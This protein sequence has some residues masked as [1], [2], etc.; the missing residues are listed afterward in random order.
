MLIRQGIWLIFI[1]LLVTCSSC[2]VEISAGSARNKQLFL[3][4]LQEQSTLLSTATQEAIWLRRLFADLSMKQS[5]Q[6]G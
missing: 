5:N 2:R 6:L 4:R 3:C 1:L